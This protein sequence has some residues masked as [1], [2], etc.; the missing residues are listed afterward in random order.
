VTNNVH[1]TGDFT[2]FRACN[3]HECC[4]WEEWAEWDTSG[5]S[6]AGNDTDRGKKT[7][8]RQAING[9]AGTYGCP[10]EATESEICT[11]CSFIESVRTHSIRKGSVTSKIS[12]GDRTSYHQMENRCP[13][14]RDN[15]KPTCEDALILETNPA[16]ASGMAIN[17]K[18]ITIFHP[19]DAGSLVFV[20][21]DGFSSGK[22]WMINKRGS[23]QTLSDQRIKSSVAHF[24]TSAV[25]KKLND[26]QVVSYKFRYSNSST[27]SP[28]KAEK[29]EL[30]VLAQSLEDNFKFAVSE[31]KKPED[32]L[33]VTYPTINIYL[34]DALKVLIEK[35]SNLDIDYQNARDRFDA[36]SAKFEQKINL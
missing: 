18:S 29:I 24:K 6:C 12:Y 19:P 21:E 23:I 7:R 35:N 31:R 5:C 34:I 20:D 17:G 13:M 22:Y 8:E 32:A 27:V 14:R 9:R 36:I 15:G 1:C 26:I 33:F 25:L 3:E 28:A 11:D 16:E 10:G 4:S 30:G 2:D